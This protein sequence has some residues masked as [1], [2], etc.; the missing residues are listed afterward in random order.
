MSSGVKFFIAAALL[1]FLHAAN[2][3]DIHILIL[4]ESVSSD[5]NAKVFD[6]VDGVYQISL[7]GEEVPARAPFF[8]ANCLEG[9]VFLPLGQAMIKSGMAERVIFMPIGT[10]GTSVRDWLVGGRAYEPMKLALKKA[11]HKNINFD[12]VLWKGDFVDAKFSE[13]RYQ[14]DVQKILKEVKLGAKTEKF[15]ISKSVSCNVKGDGY[16]KTYRWDPL[17]K[18][19]PGPDI[20]KLASKYYINECNLNDLGKKEI[21][22]LWLHAIKKADI[23]NERYQKESLLY[24]FK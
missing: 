17:Y 11:N 12:Y 22:Q 19:F 13:S 18:R 1:F 3:R 14:N 23:D 10:R 20:G 2:A 9:D 6:A 24:Y 4:Q 5:C 21:V 16:E 7:D 8:W 15:I